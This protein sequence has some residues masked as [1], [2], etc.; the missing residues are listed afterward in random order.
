MI[1]KNFIT[2][3]VNVFRFSKFINVENYRSWKRNM[4]MTF[5]S[6]KLWNILD[7]IYARSNVISM[8]NIANFIRTEKRNYQHDIMIWNTK[9]TNVINKIIN[10]CVDVIAQQ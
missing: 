9:N 3:D 2:N 1:N 5:M 4:Q 8:K 7:D 10:M 6:A